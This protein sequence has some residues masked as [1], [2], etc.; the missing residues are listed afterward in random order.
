MPTSPGKHTLT[1]E[2]VSA[3]CYFTPIALARDAATLNRCAEYF[4][5]SVYVLII[6][7]LYNYGIEFRNCKKNDLVSYLSLI[8]SNLDCSKSSLKAAVKPVY[9]AN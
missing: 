2:V 4:D 5:F 9:P 8:I 1:A 3:K 6:I 7:E